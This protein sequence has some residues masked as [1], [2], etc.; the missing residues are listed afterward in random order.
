MRQYQ[1][2]KVIELGLLFDFHRNLAAGIRAADH[3]CCSGALYRKIAGLVLPGNLLSV[4]V[5]KAISL[6]D[7]GMTTPGG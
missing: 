1:A 4:Y 3:S 7:L 2:H 6:D 5:I